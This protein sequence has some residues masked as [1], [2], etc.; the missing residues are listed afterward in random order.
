[1]N[2][3]LPQFQIFA[4]AQDIGPD[5]LVAAVDRGEAVDAALALAIAAGSIACTRPGA[6][7]ALP[8]QHE[9]SRA[10]AS[11]QPALACAPL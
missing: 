5:A 4:V 2:D 10:A 11:L 1:M 9:M 6:Q 3:S 7:A 8:S